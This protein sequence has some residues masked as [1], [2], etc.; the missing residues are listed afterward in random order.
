MGFEQVELGQKYIDAIKEYLPF[1][2]T[3]MPQKDNCITIIPTE[4]PYHCPVC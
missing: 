2:Y 3:I 1:D 4:K